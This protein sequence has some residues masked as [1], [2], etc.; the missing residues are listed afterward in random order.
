MN[1]QSRMYLPLAS[2]L[3]LMSLSLLVSRF[4]DVPHALVMTLLVIAVALELWGA[5]HLS[6][7]PAVRNSK[8]RQWKLR[9]I[10]KD[11]GRQD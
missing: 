11:Q 10:G 6:R 7:S 2:G 4:V 1:Q 8:L 5:L 3:L 9:L